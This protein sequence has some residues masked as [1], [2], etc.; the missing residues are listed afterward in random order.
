MCP[1]ARR[2]DKRQVIVG[3]LKLCI[4]GKYFVHKKGNGLVVV[5][6]FD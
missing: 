3:I 2:T 1:S 5:V 4:V 6:A